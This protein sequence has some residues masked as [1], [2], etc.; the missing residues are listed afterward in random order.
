MIVPWLIFIAVALI[1]YAGFV[2]L[3]ARLLRYR[4]SWK[5]GF[6]FAAILV[7]LVIVA[8]VLAIGQPVAIR[9]GQSVV[10]LL[11][12]L[13]FGSWFFSERGTKHSG[14]MLG[15]GG[16][17][18][19]IALAVAMMVAVVLTIVIPAQLFLSKHL[20]APP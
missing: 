7:V 6:L 13:T 17:L 2:K 4:V 5:A 1:T 9:I 19:L 15:W 3:A 12:L 14:T 18:R 20:S 10:L 16:G 11:C 8:H